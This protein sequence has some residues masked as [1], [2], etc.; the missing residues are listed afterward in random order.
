MFCLRERRDINLEYR[1]RVSYN[2]GSL[3][4]RLS[5]FLIK[6]KFFMDI[7][8]LSS[9]FFQDCIENH[10]EQ[11]LML[12]DNGRPCVLLRLKYNGKIQKFAVPFRS[13]I[14]NTAPKMQ[15]FPLPPNKNTKQGNY[16]GIHYIKIFPVSDKYVNKYRIDNDKYWTM[17]KNIISKPDNEKIIV[18]SCQSYLNDYASGNIHSMTPNINRILS[19][20]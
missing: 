14:S 9:T 20:L 5:I 2:R 6:E 1:S 15:Y 16:H 4:Q 10:T 3:Y 12:S 13:N 19:W 17:I 18:N 11:E 7:I 8:K